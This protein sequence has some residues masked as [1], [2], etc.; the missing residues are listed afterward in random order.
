M[1]KKFKLKSNQTLV[2]GDTEIDSI[3]TQ[4]GKM[5][6]CLIQNDYTLK[7]SIP[8][9]FSLKDCLILKKNN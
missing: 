6:F 5:K 8:N 1:K 4:R 9:N 3:L 2:I 7:K